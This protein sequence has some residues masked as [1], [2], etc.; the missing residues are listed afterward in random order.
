MSTK[1]PNLDSVRRQVNR[2]EPLDKDVA[3]NVIGFADFLFGRLL[4]ARRV[5][6]VLDIEFD[7]NAGD[8]AGE[9][10]D[11]YENYLATEGVVFR[12]AGTDPEGYHAGYRFDE[13]LFG[14]G[15]P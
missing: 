4:A 8:L 6:R 14:K 13:L 2:G 11:A 10:L 1:L 7:C 9:V 15:Q 3:L 12:E 5:L